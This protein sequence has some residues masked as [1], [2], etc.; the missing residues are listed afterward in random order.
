MR[1]GKKS[2]N[3]AAAGRRLFGERPQQDRQAAGLAVQ[4][5]EPIVDEET[6]MTPP[7]PEEPRVA[8]DPTQRLLTALGRFQRQVTRAEEGAPQEAWCDECMNQLITGI[9]IALGEDWDDVKEALTDTARILQTFEDAGQAG[10]CVGFLKESYEILCLMVGDLIVGNVRSGVMKKWE[11]RYER[12]LDDLATAGLTLIDDDGPVERES[13]HAPARTE[14]DD[15]DNILDDGSGIPGSVFDDAHAPSATARAFASDPGDPFA[16][17]DPGVEG[18]DDDSPFD[19]PAHRNRSQEEDH[20]AP[21]LDELLGRPVSS[22]D[23]LEDELTPDAG[24]QP[25]L[26]DDFTAETEPSFNAHAGADAP[27]S[28]VDSGD[29]AAFWDGQAVDSPVE[30]EDSGLDEGPEAPIEDAAPQVDEVAPP[31]EP[32]VAPAPEPAPAKPAPAP[33]AVQPEP[34]PEPGTPEALLRTAQRAMAAGNVSDAKLFALQL[35]VNMARLEANQVAERIALIESDIARNRDA[36]ASGELAVHEAEERVRRLEEDVARCRQEFEEKQRRIEELRG[37][38]AA[39]EG[40]VEDLNRQI[41][42]L[43]ARRDA[44]AERLAGIQSNLSDS[45]GEEQRMQAELESLE[46]EESGSRE[47]L[48][49]ARDHVRALQE[50]GAAHESRLAETQTEFARREKAVDDIENTLRHVTGEPEPAA[51]PPAPEDSAPESDAS[52]AGNGAADH[53]EAHEP[54]QAELLPADEGNG[55]GGD[56]AGN[57]APQEHAS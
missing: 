3:L 43:E 55:D 31:E 22:G 45:I 29:A 47:N 26:T 48:D 25:E 18:G 38:V 16:P 39:A 11:N 24:T 7:S 21:S 6:M 12:A 28:A 51:E 20:P 42:E 56:G 40:A 34:E 8:G 35:A 37:E 15:F 1:F 54:Q 27:E 36:V 2:R 13:A 52:A 19:S 32:A 33:A 50:S 14:P 46:E 53:G 4:T 41:A 23:D 49:G 44:E 5:L 10:Q 30:P 57:G 17:V 9:E